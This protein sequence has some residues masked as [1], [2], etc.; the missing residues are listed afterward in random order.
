MRYYFTKL[1]MAVVLANTL[2]AIKGLEVPK[3]D[4]HQIISDAVGDSLL[5]ITRMYD[6]VLSELKKRDNEMSYEEQKA[7]LTHLLKKLIAEF[8]NAQ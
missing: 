1:E 3:K 8:N 5:D 4:K 6:S 7:Q 2:N